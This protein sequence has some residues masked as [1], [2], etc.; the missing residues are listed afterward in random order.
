MCS[1]TWICHLGV[2]EVWQIHISGNLKTLSFPVSAKTAYIIVVID[3]LNFMC[4]Y[5]DW[6]EFWSTSCQ[7][8]AY[9][10][11]GIL[12]PQKN[13]WYVFWGALV[14][15]K[16][17]KKNSKNFFFTLKNWFFWKFLVLVGTQ[18]WSPGTNLG[19]QN[20]STRN[21]PCTQSNGTRNKPGTQVNGT[22]NKPGT[23]SNG[24]RNKP[25]HPNHKYP[26]QTSAPKT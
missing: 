10:F 7:L 6:S 23:Q 3:K 1:G 17:Q 11:K 15:P 12:S 14:T 8:S 26:E 25:R 18:K 19:T 2:D 4:L 21:K 5:N 9:F 16:T 24:T 13:F 20:L 22:R